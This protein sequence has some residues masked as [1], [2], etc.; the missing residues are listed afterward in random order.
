MS[1][2]VSNPKLNL[3]DKFLLSFDVAFSKKNEIVGFGLDATKRTK[4][5][6]NSFDTFLSNNI[7]R[8]VIIDNGSKLLKKSAKYTT[9][10][11]YVWRIDKKNTDLLGFQLRYVN[12][13]VFEEVKDMSQYNPQVDTTIYVDNDTL[14]KHIPDKYVVDNTGTI[15]LVLNKVNLTSIFSFEAGKVKIEEYLVYDNLRE[16]KSKLR[17]LATNGGTTFNVGKLIDGSYEQLG[18]YFFSNAVNSGYIFLYLENVTPGNISV[19]Y[20]V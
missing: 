2:F 16:F 10:G 11:T 19:T 12:D 14:F 9:D 15:K 7:S 1:I 3:Q 17:F 13:K 4:A 6:V 18:A 20:S 5:T 8:S